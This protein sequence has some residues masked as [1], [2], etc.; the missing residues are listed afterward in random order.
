VQK[1]SEKSNDE[2]WTPGLWPV[3]AAGLV[4]DDHRGSGNGRGFDKDYILPFFYFFLLS[5]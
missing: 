4:S 3:P 2:L 1:F 5:L